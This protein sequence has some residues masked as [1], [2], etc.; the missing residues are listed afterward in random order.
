MAIPHGLHSLRKQKRKNS[1]FRPLSLKSA[2]HGTLK[3][4]LAK[5]EVLLLVG[6][7]NSNSTLPELLTISENEQLSNAWVYGS[8]DEP[9]MAHL[10]S[11]NNCLPHREGKQFF[12][13][14]VNFKVDLCY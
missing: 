2:D 8:P 13:L 4:S 6:C 3:N 1:S 9:G 10:F 12:F 5:G 11:L 14:S 7:S